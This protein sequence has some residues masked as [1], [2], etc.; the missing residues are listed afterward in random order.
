MLNGPGAISPFHKEP[1][2]KNWKEA[3]VGKKQTKKTIRGLHLSYGSTLAKTS[4]NHLA[5]LLVLLL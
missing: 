1:V 5:Q 2:E 3:A 4:K